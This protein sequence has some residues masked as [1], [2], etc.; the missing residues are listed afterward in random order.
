MRPRTHHS[1]ASTVSSCCA[2]RCSSFAGLNR[3]GMLA[4]Q[5]SNAIDCS[6]LFRGDGIRQCC[7]TFSRWTDNSLFR[8]NVR[9]RQ[10]EAHDL[11]TSLERRPNPVERQ[12]RSCPRLLLPLE[13]RSESSLV[14]SSASHWKITPSRWGFDALRPTRSFIC[15]SNEIA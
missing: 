1:P 15:C 8:R 12:R 6:R 7:A 9:R 13:K 10:T 14:S 11:Q 2:R 4:N 3:S 5:L